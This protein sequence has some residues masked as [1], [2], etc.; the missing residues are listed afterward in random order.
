[1]SESDSGFVDFKTIKKS[2][3][4]LQV[5]EHYGLTHTL[6]RNGDSLS[7][8]CP[9]HGGQT[10]GQFKVSISKNCWNCFGKCKAG[11]NVLDFVSHKEKIGIRDAAIFLMERVGLSTIPAENKQTEEKIDK[12]PQGQN[13]NEEPVTTADEPKINKPLGFVLKSLDPNH[14]YLAERGFT[15][16]TVMAFGLGHCK[17]GILMERIAIPIHNL[18]GQ[19]VAYIGRWPGIPPEGK[20]KYKFPEGFKKSL[21]IFNVHRAI[22]ESST[23]PL[24]VVESVFDCM[25]IWQTGFRRIVSIMGNVISEEQIMLLLHIASSQGRI[26]LMFNEDE[27]A[28]SSCQNALM[29]LSPSCYVKTIK[30]SP[31]E[32]QP[33]Y[34]SQNK[35]TELLK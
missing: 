9:L 29:R 3:S 30:L 23:E 26:V 7:G 16:E 28:Q 20:E 21:E 33:E 32:L 1:M 8:P 34:L 6:K 24:I 27:T 18:N 17:K 12:S 10:E 19:L 5:L 13:N 14:P 22:K 35:F 15:K 31:K 11:G 4:M 2:V 25:K